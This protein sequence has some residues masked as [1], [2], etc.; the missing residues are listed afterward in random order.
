M[1]YN[2][3]CH[4]KYHMSTMICQSGKGIRTTGQVIRYYMIRY[5][6]SGC[7]LLL[8]LR[9]ILVVVECIVNEQ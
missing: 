7:T 6:C 5:E 1:H 4:H 2:V 3:K 9:F 8:S